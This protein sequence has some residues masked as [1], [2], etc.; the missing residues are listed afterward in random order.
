MKK[1]LLI[2]SILL[3]TS[4]SYAQ[5][6]QTVTIGS[7]PRTVRKAP[8]SVEMDI[9][10]FN[11]NQNL[12]ISVIKWRIF[13]YQIVLSNPRLININPLF[14]NDYIQF[15]DIFEPGRV[16]LFLIAKTVNVADV[17]IG[18]T[19]LTTLKFDR[20]LYANPVSYGLDNP[21]SFIIATAI[22]P[23]NIMLF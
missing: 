8:S 1:L 3:F 20:V 22:V 11:G 21:N 15:I 2:L 9:Y 5:E 23:S 13:F 10:I 7:I 17:P 18:G 19:L 12:K 16:N 6:L 4:Q 14:A